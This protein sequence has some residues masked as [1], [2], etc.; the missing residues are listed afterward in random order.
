MLDISKIELFD[1][2]RRK[3]TLGGRRTALIRAR[4]D[5]LLH[6]SR[7]DFENH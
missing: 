7:E 2:F 1:G 6:S 5:N 4:W 3:K